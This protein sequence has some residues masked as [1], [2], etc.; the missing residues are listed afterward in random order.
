MPFCIAVLGVLGLGNKSLDPATLEPGLGLSNQAL[1]IAFA[2]AGALA[3]TIVAYA[4]LRAQTSANEAQ[5]RSLATAEKARVY[6]EVRR[7]L[8]R[9]ASVIAAFHTV[10]AR[11]HE[12]TEDLLRSLPNQMAQTKASTEIATDQKTV[13]RFELPPRDTDHIASIIAAHHSFWA[14]IAAAQQTERPDLA[15]DQLWLARHGSGKAPSRLLNL[16]RALGFFGQKGAAS[17]STPDLLPPGTLAARGTPMT[18]DVAQDILRLSRH[19]IKNFAE[20]EIGMSMARDYAEP[21]KFK[22][23]IAKAEAHM[24]QLAE[25]ALK[26]PRDAAAL[27]ADSVTLRKV[28]EAILAAAENIPNGSM[29]ESAPEALKEQFNE[30]H[31]IVARLAG[32]AGD[33]IALLPIARNGAISSAQVEGFF[34]DLIGEAFQELATLGV[35]LNETVQMVAP[36]SHARLILARHGAGPS[37]DALAA[38]SAFI[39]GAIVLP[40]GALLCAGPPHRYVAAE[41]KANLGLALFEDLSRLYIDLS[42][43]ADGAIDLARLIPDGSTLGGDMF[44]TSY[45][46]DRATQIGALPAAFD[47]LWL[48]LRKDPEIL[49]LLTLQDAEMFEKGRFNFAR[50]IQRAEEQQMNIQDLIEGRS[51]VDLVLTLDPALAQESQSQTILPMASPETG[52]PDDTI[53]F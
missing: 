51:T 40:D 9:H 22:T 16:G 27:V 47:A 36:Q 8:I 15:L 20:S 43:D 30:L 4:A 25:A 24:G 19:F 6:A 52:N 28:F 17:R 48:M 42:S 5:N 12:I 46:Q 31:A 39:A 53:P 45:G 34:E 29:P 44:D 10:F 18:F 26:L 33:L 37:G 23:Q 49:A 7:D 21:S 2:L 35:A 38:L 1:T 50:A 11:A 41:W 3:S 13:I 32:E 14:A